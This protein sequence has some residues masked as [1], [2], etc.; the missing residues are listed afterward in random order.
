MEYLIEYMGKHWGKARRCAQCE[1]EI[2]F[3]CSSC[4]QISYC[5]QSCQT[6]HWNS[7]HRFECIQGNDDM[8]EKEGKAE[9]SRKREREE[10]PEYKEVSFED[11][12]S[13]IWVKMSQ[14]L[15]A[16]DLKN[17]KVSTVMEIRLR[18][19][20]FQQFRF[21][22]NKEF[23]YPNDERFNSLKENVIAVR[24]SSADDLIS[25]D[26]LGFKKIIDVK[27]SNNLN[28]TIKWFPPNLKYI[29]LGAE[30]N[31][32]IKL[33]PSVTH[34]T[35]G[36]DFKGKMEATW[37]DVIYFDESRT[38]SQAF[39]VDDDFVNLETL[40]MST[41]YNGA[42]LSQTTLPKLKHLQF[43]HRYNQPLPA[44]LL[45]TQLEYVRFGADFNQPLENLP[46]T[47]KV[48]VTMIDFN[49]PLPR[50]FRN[51]NIKEIHLPNIWNH[52]LDN[53]P[54]GLTTLS[55]GTDFNHPL[56]L[57][58]SVQILFLRNPLKNQVIPANIRKLQVGDIHMLREP[59]GDL[60]IL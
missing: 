8:D 9:R 55:L 49:Q 1:G 60:R 56:I 11:L 46:P 48:L 31:Q 14:F 2:R 23:S 45:K 42:L 19:A 25:L 36:R 33:P 39:F 5:G 20:F 7:Q 52:P 13:D 59:S 4:K 41:Y 47:L 58:P 28:E 12:T 38:V 18:Q 3:V 27:F 51:S 54:L 50:Y 44:S 53:L 6:Q 34:I 26:K 10:Q 57:P 15:S 21:I 40:K 43:G 22:F 17:L 35:L 30:F 24:I 37:E 32:E 29:T 16:Q